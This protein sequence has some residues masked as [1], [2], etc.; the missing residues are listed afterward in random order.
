M[1]HY[2]LFYVPFDQFLILYK[3]KYYGTWID[4]LLKNILTSTL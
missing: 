2:V 1:E 4:E 3:K